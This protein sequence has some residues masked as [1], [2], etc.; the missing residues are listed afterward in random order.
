[1]P[2][3]GSQINPKNHPKSAF[4]SWKTIKKYANPQHKT[5]KKSRASYPTLGCTHRPPTNPAFGFSNL[6][7]L[8]SRRTNLN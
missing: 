2:S 1:L 7:T 3:I 8:L 4:M 6:V 5:P